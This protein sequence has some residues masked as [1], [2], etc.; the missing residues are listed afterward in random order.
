MKKT[1]F[2]ST[3]TL[4]Q[5][6]LYKQN[7]QEQTKAVQVGFMMN[8]EGFKLIVVTAVDYAYFFNWRKNS[9]MVQPSLSP[10]TFIMNPIKV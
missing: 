1:S 5:H 6:T 4:T 7:L 2:N 9:R 3:N 8:I 10:S